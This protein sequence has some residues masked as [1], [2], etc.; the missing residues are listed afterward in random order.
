MVT[1][2]RVTTRTRKIAVRIGEGPPT[3][4]SVTQVLLRWFP[5]VQLSSAA[6]V[7]T[8]KPSFPTT[9]HGQFKPNPGP[10]FC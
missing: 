1:E 9:E 8:R 4:R 3:M 5:K 10:T 6:G 7:T 2:R